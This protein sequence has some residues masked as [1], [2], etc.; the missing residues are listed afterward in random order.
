MYPERMNVVQKLRSLVDEIKQNTNALKVQDAWILA[1][2]LLVRV[3]VNTNEASRVLKERDI[4]GFDALVSRLENPQAAQP[5]PKPAGGDSSAASSGDDT[6]EFSHDDIAAAVRAFKK[7]LK[8]V[9][10]NDES[11]LGGRQL[12]GG[13]KSEVDAIMPP[14]EFDPRIWEVLVKEGRLVNTGQGFYSLP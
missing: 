8:L 7:R 2:R 13:K 12:S 4:D 14:T 1:E 11:K 3:P 9:R 5:T 10:L 6:T